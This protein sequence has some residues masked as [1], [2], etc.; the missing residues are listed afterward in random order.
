MLL[1]A[2]LL[3]FIINYLMQFIH[4]KTLICLA[5]LLRYKGEGP[6]TFITEWSCK[7]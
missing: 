1:F 4:N 3:L 2:K 5:R 7:R 6:L